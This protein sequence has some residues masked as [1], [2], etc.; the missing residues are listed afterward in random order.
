MLLVVV[1]VAAAVVTAL[2]VIV[3]VVVVVATVL[4]VLGVAVGR[5]EEAVAGL[6]AAPVE[7]GLRS[8]TGSESDMTVELE[9]GAATGFDLGASG[10][11]E[12]WG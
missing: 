7:C 2:F 5:T 1:A 4:M 10:D 11:A 6:A 3:V 12:V 9:A 8:G